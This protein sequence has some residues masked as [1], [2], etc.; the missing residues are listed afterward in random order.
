QV[1]VR[2]SRGPLTNLHLLN[3]RG[4]WDDVRARMGDAAWAD[5]RRTGEMAVACFPAS[6]YAGIDLLI[7][8]DYRRHAVLEVN[9]FGD[10][11]PGV[12]WDGMDTYTTEIVAMLTP[13][14]EQRTEN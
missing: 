14:G 13:A 8:A 12:L 9:A 11:L 7:A 3:Q 4:P 2:M 5:A 1:V 10:L 6:L